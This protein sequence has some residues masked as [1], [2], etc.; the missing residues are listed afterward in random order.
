[1]PNLQLRSELWNYPLSFSEFLVLAWS[2]FPLKGSSNVFHF[3]NNFRVWIILLLILLIS[4]KEITRVVRLCG[5]VG[6]VVL[7]G[8]WHNLYIYIS[9]QNKYML[10]KCQ[11]WLKNKAYYYGHVKKWRF[12]SVGL[13]EPR[14]WRM[15]N[16][17]YRRIEVSWD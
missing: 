3:V 2:G 4:G 8:N 7:F 16:M 14:V 11:Y 13:G 17:N 12:S 15:K 5:C 1:M 6:Y 9:W 10:A